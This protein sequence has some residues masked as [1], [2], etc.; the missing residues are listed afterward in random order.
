MTACVCL[1]HNNIL[2]CFYLCSALR[3]IRELLPV[4]WIE[5]RKANDDNDSDKDASSGASSER[6]LRLMAPVLEDEWV[7]L[8]PVMIQAR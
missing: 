6:A 1:C 5:F 8:V 3:G 7:K 4:D 2:Q